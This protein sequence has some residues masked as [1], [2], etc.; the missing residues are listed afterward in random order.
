MVH[1]QPVTFT[2]ATSASNGSYV[3]I[4]GFAVF[5]VTDVSANSISVQAVT[6]VSADP[7]DAV[8][9]SRTARAPDPLVIR[10]P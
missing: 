5:E 9:S 1:V 10:K 2:V 4:I 6:G 7:A 3:D 8:A